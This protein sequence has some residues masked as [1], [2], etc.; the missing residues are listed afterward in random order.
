M[1]IL[2]H[3]KS[4]PSSNTVEH[5]GTNMSRPGNEPV[6]KY[7]NSLCYCHLEPLQYLC[8]YENS[9]QYNISLGVLLGLSRL[10]VDQGFT[11]VADCSLA[12]KTFFPFGKS[13]HQSSFQG[14]DYSLDNSNLITNN[15]AWPYRYTSVYTNRGGLCTRKDS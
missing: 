7:L 3:V 12:N 8:L 5:P 14:E 4:S 15:P 11:V 13:R 2:D 10:D 9:I 6:E 1:E